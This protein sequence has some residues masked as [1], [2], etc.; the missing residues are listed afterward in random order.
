MHQHRGAKVKARPTP[1]DFVAACRLLATV[2]G[3]ATAPY[4][5]DHDEELWRHWFK[6]AQR[7]RD[8]SYWEETADLVLD[9]FELLAGPR[10]CEALF[11]G[12]LAWLKR[13]PGARKQYEDGDDMSRA[14][15]VDWY[16]RVV[17]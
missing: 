7:P 10:D 8:G 15:L 9:Y 16:L 4:Q 6:N 2:D 11:E 17:R 1:Y 5:H 13:S 14:A 12:F 3:L